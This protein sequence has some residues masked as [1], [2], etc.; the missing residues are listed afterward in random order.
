MAA[1]SVER[2]VSVGP[3]A[4]SVSLSEEVKHHSLWCRHVGRALEVLLHNAGYSMEAQRRSLGFFKNYVA[5]NLGQS[6]MTDDGTPVELSWDWGTTDN[7]QPTIRYSIEPIGFQAGSPLDPL[8]SM[9]VLVLQERLNRALPNMNLEWFDYFTKYF[10]NPGEYNQ[11]CSASWIYALYF[12]IKELL[13]NQKGRPEQDVPDHNSSVFYGF[14]ITETE[15]TTKVYFFP[16]YRAA[17]CGQSNLEILFQGIQNAPGCTEENLHALSVFRNFSENTGNQLLE[18]E[19]LAID[20]IK[21]SE[22]RFKIYFRC[23]ET[24]FE[25]LS[26]IMTLGGRTRTSKMERGLAELY[27]L[28]KLLFEVDESDELAENNHRTAGMLYN[29]EF[30][31]GDKSPVAKVYFPVRHYSRTDKL[32]IQGLDE[33]FKSRQR[34]RHMAAYSQA[35]NDLFGSELLMTQAGVQTYVGCAIRP[36]GVLRVVSYLKPPLS[37]RPITNM[38]GL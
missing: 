30:R 9:A 3:Q 4:D 28:W 10:N 22:A 21:P 18:Y 38:K 31:L 25:S 11:A 6:F 19:M 15:T 24:S 20:L 16:K 27:S 13:N 1:A 5:P 7:S 8:N 32:V 33:Y 14:D 35:M 34:G 36:E 26:N 23:R 12:F 37:E 2:I 29:V 17:E